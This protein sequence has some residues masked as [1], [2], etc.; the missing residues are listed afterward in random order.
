MFSTYLGQFQSA[1]RL[2]AIKFFIGTD[3]VGIFAVAHGMFQQVTALLPIA[4]VVDPLVAQ[5]LHRRET[6]VRLLQKS[7][8]YQVIGYAIAAPVASILLPVILLPFFPHYAAAFALFPF[9]A[10][11]YLPGA[12]GSGLRSAFFALKMQ[13]SLFFAVLKMTV[14]S[15]LS[16]PLLLPLLGL[17]GAALEFVLTR[18]V[19]A[20]D[21]YRIL[22]K[23]LPEFSLTVRDL[24][25]LDRDDRRLLKG[26]ARRIPFAR[27]VL[28]RLL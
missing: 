9:L 28:A 1:A 25:S 5:Y 24:V 22:R 3:A 20:L 19:F 4:R 27:V 21:R 13:R 7:V 2:W 16:L 15:L 8:K 18:A 6:M 12:V 11:A 26:M 17:Y 10:A 23:V 14:L